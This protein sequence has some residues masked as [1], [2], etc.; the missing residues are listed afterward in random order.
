MINIFN[1]Q[2]RRNAALVKA[3]TKGDLG[4]VLSLLEKGAEVNQPNT[5]GPLFMAAYGGDT[6]GH[7]LVLEALLARGANVDERNSVN[8]TALMGAA[9][10]GHKG[11]AQILLSAGADPTLTGRDKTA[12]QWALTSGS[13]DTIYLLQ[14]KPQ[15][16]EDAPDEV[17]TLQSIGNRTVEEVFNFASK[18]RITFV[19]NGA[20]GPVEA[21]TRQNFRDIAD[22]D[23]LRAAYAQY[24]AKGGTR[25]E[26]EVFPE[27]LVKVRPTGKDRSHG[28]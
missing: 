7:H 23:A 22:R 18:E 4:K 27:V 28:R 13:E 12:F 2:K 3:C 15:R 5:D 24:V 26:S 19:R 1:A 17:T 16:R 14:P 8:C 21:V 9:N 6:D 20:D 11:A 25:E 10:R